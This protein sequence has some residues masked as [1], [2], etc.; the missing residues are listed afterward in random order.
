MDMSYIMP[1][2]APT[3][4]PAVFKREP[5]AGMAPRPF[6]ASGSSVPLPAPV[7]GM[8]VERDSHPAVL[9]SQAVV[10]GTDTP[11]T[12]PKEVIPSVEAGGTEIVDGPAGIS[13]PPLA[14]GKASSTPGSSHEPAKPQPDMNPDEAEL[15]FEADVE[16]EP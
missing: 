5:Q 16:P 3:Q 15:D 9:G 13:P 7:T 8:N 2:P 1:Q 11:G 10:A 12:G 6:T 4:W 14:A